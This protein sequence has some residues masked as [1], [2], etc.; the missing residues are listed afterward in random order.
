MWDEGWRRVLAATVAFG[1]VFFSL[2]Q[3]KLPGYLLPLLPTA[4]ALVGDAAARAVEPR[5]PL[6]LSAFLL[7]L[8]PVAAGMLPDALLGGIR[9]AQWEGMPWEYFAAALIPAAA[10][11]VLSWKGWRVA[12]AA[13]VAALMA[14]G[15][16]YIKLSA[17]PVVDRVVSARGLWQRVRPVKDAVCIEELHRSYRYGLRYYSVEPLPDCEETERAIHLTQPGGRLPVLNVVGAP[18]R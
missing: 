4:F 7:A 13:L 2:S 3:N 11:W 9:R 17:Y 15:V 1:F 12:A 5:R 18:P 16:L 6:A 8:I 10:V 14:G